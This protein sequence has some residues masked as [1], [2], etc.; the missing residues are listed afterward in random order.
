MASPT[1][2]LKY[3]TFQYFYKQTRSLATSFDGFNSSAAQLP[4]ELLRCRVALI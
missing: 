3:T 4:G 1:N 2:N